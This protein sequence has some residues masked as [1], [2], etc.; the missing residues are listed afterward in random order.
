MRETTPITASLRQ[1]LEEV[2]SQL[3]VKFRQRVSLGAQIN[4]TGWLR[5]F[6]QAIA[7]A[8]EA[9]LR[10]APGRSREGLLALYDVGLELAAK[11]NFSSA[12]GSP[13]LLEL[14]REVFPRIA[15]LLAE[16]PREV[17]GRLSNAIL[18]LN[19]SAPLA[20]GRW[21]QQLDGTAR[22]CKSAEQLL[23]LGKFLGWTSGVASLRK[24]AVPLAASLP[25]S[26]LRSI[27]ALERDVPSG[28]VYAY[29]QRFAEYAWQPDLAETGASGVKEVAICG[30]FRGLGGNFLSPPRCYLADSTIHVTDGATHWE[31]HADRFGNSFH[32]TTAT[33]ADTVGAVPKP[34]VSLAGEIDW[35]EQRLLRPDLASPTSQVY[36]GQ[37]LA[38]TIASSYHVYLFARPSG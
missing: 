18:N 14:W 15:A 10:E 3:N 7:P 32:R 23:E 19:Q 31:L 6:E 27:L 22:E 5:I 12:G 29:F 13:K 36:D 28:F 9:I 33:R 26:I 21:L 38:V 11:G 8:V 24:A 25:E 35:G 37:T 4:G 34:S 16:K 20:A 1:L 17:A 2:R 30:D